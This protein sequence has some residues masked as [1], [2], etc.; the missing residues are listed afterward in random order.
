MAKADLIVI[1]AGPAGCAAAI[2]ACQLGLRVVALEAHLHP[3]VSPGETL[4][5]GIEP[6][7]EQLGVAGQVN[8]A[9]FHRHL[10]ISIDHEGSR[11]FHPYGQDRRG[12]WRGFQVERRSFHAILRRAAVDAGTTLITGC[13]PK[14]LLVSDGRVLGVRLGNGRQH[15]GR[16]TIDATG[17]NAWVAKQLGIRAE[18][19]SPP[20]GARFGWRPRS[21]RDCDGQPVFRYC[22]DGWNWE[23]PLSGDRTAWVELRVQD[24]STSIPTAVDLT[25]RYRRECAGSGYVLLGDAAATLDPASSHGVLRALMSGILCSHLIAGCERADVCETHAAAAY[26]RWFSEQ[27]LA[28]EARLTDHYRESPLGSQFSTSSGTNLGS[29]G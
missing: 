9:G 24:S 26:R 21:Q 18:P 22:R 17:R 10:G 16:W 2:R 28:D 20:L 25:W 13:R 14:K 4:H 11:V 27:Y 1:G 6:I 29:C 12:I 15:L 19:R 23:A 5:P 7:L 8:S 3:K